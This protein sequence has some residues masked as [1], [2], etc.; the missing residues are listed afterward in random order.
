MNTELERSSQLEINSSLWMNEEAN[1]QPQWLEERSIRAGMAY[2]QRN[3]APLLVPAR[4]Q[5]LQDDLFRLH[6]FGGAVSQ[7]DAFVCTEGKYGYQLDLP[8]ELDL[9]S[10]HC[11]DEAMSLSCR[12]H[13]SGMCFQHTTLWLVLFG[14]TVGCIWGICSLI[15]LLA[16]ALKASSSGVVLFHLCVGH[17][18]SVLR[19]H[20]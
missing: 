19:C 16:L 11:L 17:G 7:P 14:P 3:E 15:Y 12:P 8:Q 18:P 9:A 20:L 1:A 6:Y 4:K 2:P 13:V 10:S 5:S